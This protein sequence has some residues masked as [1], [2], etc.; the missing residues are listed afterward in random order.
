MTY[1]FIIQIIWKPFRA[2]IFTTL[3]NE[4]EKYTPHLARYRFHCVRRVL[5]KA[6]PRPSGLQP[7]V[8]DGAVARGPV[9]I[10]VFLPSGTNMHRSGS[11]LGVNM[12]DGT[13]EFVYHLTI[14]IVWQYASSLSGSVNRRINKERQRFS[15]SNKHWKKGL[16]SK[17]IQ[18]IK[19]VTKF[20][21]TVVNFAP[22]NQMQI[23]ACAWIYR[24]T[25]KLWKIRTGPPRGPPGLWAAEP[26]SRRSPG[27]AGL[28]LA[29]PVL[30]C[31]NFLSCRFPSPDG[32]VLGQMTRGQVCWL[33]LWVSESRLGVF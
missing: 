17:R 4:N 24:W 31:C 25:K 14:W 3:L 15:L 10:T 21:V 7:T 23:S 27:A 8:R 2:V 5:L 13:F 11:G 20:K 29:K 1:N 28:L 32:K 9:R 6:G 18:M 16:G 26:L 19:M 30:E 12:D 22:P 33:C